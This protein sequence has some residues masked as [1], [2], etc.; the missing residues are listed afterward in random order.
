M[1]LK[2]Y[3]YA[4]RRNALW[5]VL[6]AAL[7]AVVTLWLTRTMPRQ[8]S[9]SALLYTGITSGYSLTSEGGS[10]TADYLSTSNAFDNLVSTVTSRE[11]ILQVSERLL[12]R[13]LMLAG[14]DPL[15]LGTEGF[16]DLQERL[17]AAVRARVVIPGNE[18]ATYVRVDSLAHAVGMNPIKGL[19]FEEPQSAYSIATIQTDLTAN[20]K[21]DSD[22]LELGYQSNDPAITHGV[23][24]ILI[25]VFTQ[26]YAGFKA[27]QTGPVVE[28]YEN[29][30]AQN[31]ERL[32]VAENRRKSFDQQNAITDFDQQI[33]LITTTR[34][35]L[36]E[37]RDKERMARDA[38]YASMTA[39]GRR[40][41]DNARTTA[42]NA[43]LTTKRSELAAVNNQLA[44]A[45]VYGQSKAVI[46]QLSERAERLSDEL[47]VAARKYYQIGSAPESVGQ[48]K[49]LEEWLLKVV[50]YEESSARL[51][52]YESRMR[53]YDARVAQFAPLGATL[54]QLDREVELAEKDYL[55][56]LQVLNQARLRQ[57]DLRM[58]GP[59]KLVDAP[60]YSLQPLPSKRK[61]LALAASMGTLLLL[62]IGLIGREL[63]DQRLRHPDRAEALT[64]LPLAA[65]FPA[66]RHGRSFAQNRHIHALLEQL[67]G[68]IAVY[69]DSSKV[70]HRR[71]MVSILSTYPTDVRTWLASELARRYRESD[72]RVAYIRPPHERTPA[73]DAPDTFTYDIRNDYA[74][75]LN[76][77]DLFGGRGE[78]DLAIYDLI[79]LELP[80]LMRHSLPTHLLRQNSILF[81]ALD[82]QE[83]WARNDSDL[84]R[85]LKQA[86]PL[87][88]MSILMQA[89]LGLLGLRTL[90]REYGAGTPTGKAA[91]ARTSVSDLD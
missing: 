87:P 59:L 31:K 37:E 6:L 18:Q 11:T 85:I 32:Q 80:D 2:V 72:Y 74:E 71:L 45:Q 77:E 66:T 81:V 55:A 75:S 86:T 15:V 19:F 5:L 48:A 78:I 4:L 89:E 38:A 67:R 33:K 9:S 54:T 20:R 26:R 57:Q 16:R 12:A 50:A 43:E 73:P 65:A 46:E 21:K 3:L 10:R 63:L 7:A 90:R 88:T 60:N 49:L 84:I 8:Y 56:T 1:S 29:L 76:V 91:P 27:S 39:L 79:I 68:V 17:P 47:R 53:K 14:P 23:L 35:Q 70:P 36:T 13:H 64:G 61:V 30:L 28:Y 62:T 44:N 51:N 34:E 41:Q 69:R 83:R 22:M 42:T 82:A 40:L 58:T 25:D 52:S 24:T